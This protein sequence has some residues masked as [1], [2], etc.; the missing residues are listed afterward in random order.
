M[1]KLLL[2]SALSL[3][4]SIAHSASVS[5][6]CENGGFTI[7]FDV[8]ETESCSVDQTLTVNGEVSSEN[9]L[10]SETSSRSITLND[11][12][13]ANA[14]VDMTCS[15]AFSNYSLSTSVSTT[16]GCVGE[17]PDTDDAT[18]ATDTD[19]DVVT[20]PGDTTGDDLEALSEELNDL[21][22][23]FTDEAEDINNSF[24]GSSFR[25]MIV[26]FRKDFL[27]RVAE[28]RFYSVEFFYTSPEAAELIYSARNVVNSIIESIE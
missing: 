2:V 8:S 21:I 15:T 10:I 23:F 6:S 27:V 17:I 13:E 25:D 16:N 7:N 11:G 1:K 14:S 3:T 28:S 9:Y 24:V 5:S 19:V 12:D 4:A 26:E 22:K 20:S 18:D